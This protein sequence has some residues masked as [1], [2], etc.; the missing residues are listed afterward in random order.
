VTV[1]TGTP[2]AKAP[3]QSSVEVLRHDGLDLS[4]NPG[5]PGVQES[6]RE[7]FEDELGR[8][9]IRLVH[10]HN[11]HHFSTAPAEALLSLRKPLDLVLMHTYHSLWREE[12]SVEIAKVCGRWDVH[13]AV[14]DFLRGACAE[15][16]GVDDVKRIYLG[17]D[18]DP[19]L[20]VPELADPAPGEPG[21]V[22]LPARLIPDKGAELAVKAIARVIEDR[23]KTQPL[24]VLM[25]TPD[26]V[27]FHGEKVGFRR[28]LAREIA[29]LGIRDHVSFQEAGV[30]RM[31]E[32]YRQSRVVIHP[33]RFDEPMGLAPLE[34][35]CAARPVIATRKGGLSEGI[36]EDGVFGYLVPHLDAE[37]LAQ[38]ITQLL[39]EPEEA[40][41]MGKRGRQRITHD[42][43]LAKCY[44]P[45]VVDEYRSRL[46]GYQGA[47][48]Y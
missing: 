8:R 22:L 34:A 19:Y 23:P 26:S 44:L 40:R 47:V 21:I 7:W 39:N 5:A 16:L 24:L 10:G 45:P 12:E 1:F 2:D 13:F 28:W 42:F 31:P 4:R 38:R 18:T 32:L 3:S 14:S 29:R 33:S 48:P 36:G 37:M 17:I 27:D 43:D 30:E 25:N 46:A 15:V 35:M 9:G 11:L 20:S 41:V 6:L